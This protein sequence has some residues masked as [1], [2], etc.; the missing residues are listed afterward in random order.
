MHNINN[1]GSGN[2][3]PAKNQFSITDSP[4]F[5]KANHDAMSA[6]KTSV[7]KLKA[8]RERFFR[9]EGKGR[10]KVELGKPLLSWQEHIRERRR[11]CKMTIC[12]RGCRFR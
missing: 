11:R 9:E 12:G 8:E 7:A 2:G 5:R 4:A 10:R 6:V 3:R 1:G